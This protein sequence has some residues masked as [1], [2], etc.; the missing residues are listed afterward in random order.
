LL[1]PTNPHGDLTQTKIIRNV[2]ALKILYLKENNFILN[3]S[4]C[5]QT[6]AADAQVAE[7]QLLIED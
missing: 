2:T 4:E 5:L 3:L 1:L 6:L 7:G